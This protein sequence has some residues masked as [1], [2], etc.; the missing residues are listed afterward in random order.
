MSGYQNFLED[1]E[2]I[3]KELVRRGIVLNIDWSDELQLRA[4]ASEALDHVTDAAKIPVDQPVDYEH[5]AK[6]DLFGLAGVMLKMM[7]ESARHGVQ[8]HGGPVWKAFAKIL[9][10]EAERRG[11]TGE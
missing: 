5:L 11:L 8:T 9:W 2:Q 10:S 4:L 7:A 1:S 3:E 6:A